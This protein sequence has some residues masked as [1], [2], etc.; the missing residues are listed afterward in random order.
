[1]KVTGKPFLVAGSPMG[2]TIITSVLHTLINV[3]D[4]GYD[5]QRAVHAPRFHHQWQPDS[6]WMEP[7]FSADVR[8]KLG[9]LGHS[10]RDR[11]FMGA[12]QLIIYDPEQCYYWGGADGRRASGAAGANIG[13]QQSE[14]MAERCRL[15][16]GGNQSVVP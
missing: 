5:A 6:L 9:E 16:T 2:T 10:F 11:A 4:F 8:E 3:I 13:E 7:E 12:V 15:A 1:M 14:A